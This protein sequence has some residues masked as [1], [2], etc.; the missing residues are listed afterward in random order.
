ML[1]Y[2]ARRRPAPKTTPKTL[3][4]RDMSEIGS[5]ASAAAADT[6]WQWRRAPEGDASAHA[7]AAARRRGVLGG[8]VGLLVASGLY[9][10]KPEAALVVASIAAATTTLALVSPLGGFRRLTRVM[11]AFA[12]GLG[13]ALT[14]LLMAIAYYLLFLPCGLLLRATG[15][16]RITRGADVR[17]ASYWEEPTAPPPSLDAYRKPF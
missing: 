11:E 12:H 2:R 1:T 9:F 7:A 15:K 14:W 10:W 17:R 16:L 13:L 5:A 4:T 8:V 6:A 3:A